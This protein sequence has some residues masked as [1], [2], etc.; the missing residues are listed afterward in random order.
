MR[1]S[2]VSQETFGL[3]IFEFPVF[4]QLLAESSVPSSPNKSKRNSAQSIH[5]RSLSGSNSVQGGDHG[6]AYQ[7]AIR[8][9]NLETLALGFDALEQFAIVYDQI[10]K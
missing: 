4:D 6:S 3:D 2:N 1:L 5:R 7:Q 9:Y 8:M 10:S